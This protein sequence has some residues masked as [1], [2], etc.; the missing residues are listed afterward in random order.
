MRN[1]NRRES[2]R[3][4]HRERE[5]E[6]K[7]AGQQKVTLFPSESSSTAWAAEN[8]FH[9]SGRLTLSRKEEVASKCL[10]MKKSSST[11]QEIKSNLS[12]ISL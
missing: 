9:F 3:V 12:M 1:T 7:A 8:H 10:L 6:Q 11:K 4:G 5:R 2:D